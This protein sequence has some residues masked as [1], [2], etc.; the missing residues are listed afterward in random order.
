MAGRG[1]GSE[2]EETRRP[3]L[4][5]YGP[6]KLL[7]YGPKKLSYESLKPRG[8]DQAPA[9]ANLTLPRQEA[10][11]LWTLPRQ[12]TPSLSATKRCGHERR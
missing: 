4:L 10:P 1:R 5:M 9:L 7:M 2:R 3:H 8:G 11:S 6:K 12:Q